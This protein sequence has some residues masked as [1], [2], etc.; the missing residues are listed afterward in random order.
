M[1]IDMVFACGDSCLLRLGHSPAGVAIA[2][3]TESESDY[4]HRCLKG[5]SFHLIFSKSKK[6]SENYENC[7]N[8]FYSSIYTRLKKVWCY[9]LYLRHLCQS[10]CASSLQLKKPSRDSALKRSK[11]DHQPLSMV[12]LRNFW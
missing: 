3:I 12:N 9:D 5:T 1:L 2:S 11:R 7:T 8:K 6:S 10:N 4:A